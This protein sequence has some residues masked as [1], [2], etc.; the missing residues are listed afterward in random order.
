MFMK[1]IFILPLLI[2]FL[3]GCS[4]G[5]GTNQGVVDCYSI[6]VLDSNNSFTV[7]YEK[8]I[9]NVYLYGSSDG[10]LICSNVRYQ[11]YSANFDQIIDIGIKVHKDIYDTD[12]VT[13]QPY[14][15]VGGIVRETGYYLNL[16]SK[17]IDCVT[18]WTSLPDDYKSPDVKTDHS[19]KEVYEFA[20]H[21]FLFETGEQSVYSGVYQVYLDKTDISLERHSYIQLGSDSVISYKTKW[22]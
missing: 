7:T 3:S 18:K 6:S 12:G 2:A 20:K 11:G 15:Y 9:E 14:G 10:Q 13:Y 17:T 5:A 22:F 4:Q 19:A 1:K 21:G 16:D 8:K